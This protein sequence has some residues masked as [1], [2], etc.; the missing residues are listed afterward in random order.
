M[1]DRFFQAVRRGMIRIKDNPQLVYTLVVALVI[2]AAFIF[3]ANRFVTVA[4]DAQDRLVNTRIGALQ[5]AFSVLASDHIDDPQYLQ[6]NI[7]KL[8][9]L[10]PTIR[11]FKIIRIDTEKPLI[12]ASLDKQEVGMF[13]S[14]DNILFALASSNHE[15]S[16]TV[17]DTFG[18]E[19]AYKT[20]RYVAN[21]ASLSEAILMTKE[22]LS[23]A[24]KK[25]DE[26]IRNSIILFI[27][28]I[29]LIMIL[30]FRHSRIIDYTVLYRKLKEVDQLKDDFI[31]MASHE[32][33]TPLT[34][35]RGYAENVRD[36][37]SDSIKKYGQIIDDAALQLDAFVVDMLD[38]SRIEQG[39]MNFTIAT[40]DLAFVV[41]KYI[42]R[43]S[44]TAQ[45][46]GLTLSIVAPE[47]IRINADEARLGQVLI[48]LVGNA[49]KYTKQGGV[50][51]T[52]SK[53]DGKAAI[54]VSDTG[55][56]MCAEDQKKL[57]QKFYRI[58]SKET[59]GIT[60][61]GLGLWITAQIVEKMNGIISVES[62]QGKGTDFVVIFPLSE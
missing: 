34:L 44:V 46:K 11:E 10:N 1:F 58:K 4:L 41:H 30:F 8:A 6:S 52:I 12:I 26:N 51:V 62:I 5:D 39:R 54:R 21:D 14:A 20:V 3:I 37:G 55:I 23:E 29:L 17:E 48:N 31:S 56:G 60:G 18:N 13:V 42:D 24:D 49:I 43:Y 45:E 35:I 9:T 32:L 59:E 50:T 53:T 19:R 7:E 15:Q 25:I 36:E 33:R 27:G 22:S 38:V 2:T 28:I 57:F 47:G 16:F 61:T 40:H